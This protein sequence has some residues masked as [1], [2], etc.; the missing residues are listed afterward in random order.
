[1]KNIKIIPI[2]ALAAITPIFNSC[3]NLDLS[4]QSSVTQDQYFVEASQLR[5]YIASFYG[6]LPSHNN[7]D[8][9]RYGIDYDHTDNQ[10]HQSYPNDM[11]LDGQ[12]RVPSGGGEYEFTKIYDINYFFDQVNARLAEGRLSDSD[13]VERVI[14]EAH[15]F[16]ALAFFQKYER[17]GDFPIVTTTLAA[18]KEVLKAA[19]IRQP[20][21][22]VA[23]F[24][25]SELDLAIEKMAKD[26]AVDGNIRNTLSVDVAR[27]FKARV[28]LFEAS[29]LTNFKGTSFVPGGPEWPGVVSHPD[30]TYV[31]GSID[32]EIE[33]FL[34]EAMKE[35]KVVADKYYTQLT[36][37]NGVAPQSYTETNEYFSMFG[38]KDMSEY[39]EILMW[40][41]YNNALS[42]YSVNRIQKDAGGG[43]SAVGATRGLVN[44]F[45]DKGGLP[46]Y[47]EGAQYTLEDEYNIYKVRQ[48]H[49]GWDK[50]QS[51]PERLETNHYDLSKAPSCYPEVGRDSRIELMLGVPNQESLWV[52]EYSYSGNK[53][54]FYSQPAPDILAADGRYSTGYVSRKGQSPDP[55]L[56]MGGGPGCILFRAAES[57]LIYMEA[58]YMKNGT[59]DSDADKYWRALRTRAM[60][61]PDY[62]KTIAATDMA[63]EAASEF[64]DWGIYSGGKLVDATLYSIR[65]ERRCE[66]SFEGY[67]EQDL[68]RWRSMDQLIDKKYKMQGMWL[69]PDEAIAGSDFNYNLYDY[70]IK[71]KNQQDNLVDEQGGAISPRSEGNF[72]YPYGIKPSHLAHDGYT[73]KMAHYLSPISTDEFTLTTPDEISPEGSSLYQNPY[74][75]TDANSTAI[76]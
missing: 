6:W 69:W 20:R 39:P 52:N 4:P 74:W 70:E 9:G 29:W 36:P 7:M 59:I 12:T 34:S 11:M 60:I 51:D 61:D 32:D 47:A 8:Y 48:G 17:L 58:S 33:F 41:A 42:A 35:S 72:L 56:E 26:D 63:K 38:A 71:G 15:F 57:L 67:R 54:P 3:T 22:E 50:W 31:A 2:L 49:T 66:F 16:R 46:Y 55:N 10:V 30:F 43:N 28:A 14:G 37:N 40:K 25:L 64:Y 1:M 23:R 45:V 53:V 76:K 75:L 73:W 13:E 65:R 5:A 68:R 62:N 24:I 21:N 44:S 18:D 19:S 27:Q